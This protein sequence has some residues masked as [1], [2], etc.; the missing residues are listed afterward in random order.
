MIIAY[1]RWSDAAFQDES[2]RLQYFDNE[3]ILEEV[4][5]LVRETPTHI[6]LAMDYNASD[7]SYRHVCHIPKKMIL[8]MRTVKVEEMKKYKCQ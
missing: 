5:I 2:V 4:G 6:S 3:C 7:D 1:V 8:E